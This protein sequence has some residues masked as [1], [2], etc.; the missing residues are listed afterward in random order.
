MTARIVRLNAGEG[1]RWRS[2]RLQA[3]EDAPHAFGTSY[4]EALQWDVM[5]WEAQVVEFATFVAVVHG[6]DVGVAR[7]APIQRCARES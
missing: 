2:I 6:R 7:G 1:Q 3:L 4:I 5:R